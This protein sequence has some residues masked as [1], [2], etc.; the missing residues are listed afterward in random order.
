M[1]PL[2]LVSHIGSLLRTLDLANLSLACKSYR[3]VL[4]RLLFRRI[5]LSDKLIAN[6][7]S[8]LPL[9]LGKEALNRST[10]HLTLRH[11]EGISNS[12][13]PYSLYRH[14]ELF[15]FI[16]S[17]QLDIHDREDEGGDL[18]GLTKT[19]D[20]LGHFVRFVANSGIPPSVEHIRLNVVTAWR[21]NLR[22]FGDL[23]SL[24]SLKT[25]DLRWNTETDRRG[26][27]LG[28][29]RKVLELSTESLTRLTLHLQGSEVMEMNIGKMIPIVTAHPNLTHL[30]MCGL[31]MQLEPHDE[32]FIPHL[33]Q[34]TKLESLRLG[35]SFSD[36]EPTFLA[37]LIRPVEDLCLSCRNL[38]T[39]VLVDYFVSHLIERDCIECPLII[40]REPNKVR[41]TVDYD[42][43]WMCRRKKHC[44]CL[45]EAL[46]GWEDD[47][48]DESDT[49][50][51]EDG[52][53]EAHDQVHD[54]DDVTEL[55]S[56]DEG[57]IGEDIFIGS[58]GDANEVN[59]DD[60]DSSETEEE[61]EMTIE[62]WQS[63]AL[64]YQALLLI[65]IWDQEARDDWNLFFGDFF[66]GLL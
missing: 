20:D 45:G 26:I 8:L 61:T 9:V 13:E 25:F 35:C 42:H 41:I 47:A 28:F 52:T 15:P 2:E 48:E 30:D 49:E 12:S 31:N 32:P 60:E 36:G 38:T 46:V 55:G 65:E 57:D 64:T 66:H 4:K 43:Y 17:L 3:A 16:T 10:R 40:H 33:A 34:L 6:A 56:E 63:I 19:L 21:E 44:R 27:Y 62:E 53:D 51:E 18:D 54:D 39:C 37:S 22:T 59:S 24:P 5:R 23:P 14:I 7:A 1:L 58:D 11:S 29:V 50:D